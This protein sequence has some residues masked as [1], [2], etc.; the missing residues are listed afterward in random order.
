MPEENRRHVRRRARRIRK[1]NKTKYT[2]KDYMQ[3]GIVILVILGILAA[4]FIL[5]SND[6]I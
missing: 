3:F 4:A 6:P 5:T 2:R 1:A